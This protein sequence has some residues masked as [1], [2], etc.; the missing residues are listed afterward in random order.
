MFGGAALGL[1]ATGYSV[2][3]DVIKTIQHSKFHAV[4]AS[5]LT[6]MAPVGLCFVSMEW[7]DRY[8]HLAAIYILV[9][10]GI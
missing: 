1:H 5:P 9:G 2:I 6:I 8:N 10:A 7:Y 4:V 3:P